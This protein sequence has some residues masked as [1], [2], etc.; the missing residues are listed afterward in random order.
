MI[1]YLLTS[2]GHRRVGLGHWES[3]GDNTVNIEDRIP[4]DPQPLTK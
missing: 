1:G 4:V 3:I 2:S